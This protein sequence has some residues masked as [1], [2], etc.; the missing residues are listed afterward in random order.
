MNLDLA[1]IR[2][3]GLGDKVE[4]M[5]ILLALWKLRALLEGGL[6]LRTACD[7]QVA[8]NAIK[9]T[10]A[11]ISLPDLKALE[12]SLLPLI[13]ECASSMIV[14]QV[15]FNDKLKKGKEEEKASSADDNE[16]SGGEQ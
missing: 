15:A 6:R 16:D 4:K 8:G 12:E 5:L 1:Q 2:G 13:K 14:K 11:D 7:L 9:A 10:N 3:Y